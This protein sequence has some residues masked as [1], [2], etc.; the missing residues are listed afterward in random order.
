MRPLWPP[1]AET[2]LSGLFWLP[3]RKHD[4]ELEFLADFHIFC[5][6]FCPDRSELFQFKIRRLYKK[7]CLFN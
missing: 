4:L 7:L 1:L 3:R 2:H 5:T 6:K